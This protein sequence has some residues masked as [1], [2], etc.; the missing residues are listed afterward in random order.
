MEYARLN[1]G[2]AIKMSQ[3]EEKLPQWIPNVLRQQQNDFDCGVLVLMY[4]EKLLSKE[5]EE[6]RLMILVSY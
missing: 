3:W 5:L 6:V 4:V 1:R 2:S